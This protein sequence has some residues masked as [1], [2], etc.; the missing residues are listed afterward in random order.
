MRWL[1]CLLGLHDVKIEKYNDAEMRDWVVHTCRRLG[2]KF[3]KT[4]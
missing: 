1:M 2:C 3:N 4:Y